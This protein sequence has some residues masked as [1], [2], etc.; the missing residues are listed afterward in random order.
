TS[1]LSGLFFG[2]WPIL[3]R[4]RRTN[5]SLREGGRHAWTRERRR[6][7]AGIVIGEVALS[8][9]LLTG[10]GLLL[11]SFVRLSGVNPGFDGKNVMTMFSLIPPARYPTPQSWATYERNAIARLQR[12]PGVTQVGAINTLPLSNIGDNTSIDV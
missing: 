11:R 10:A 6:L 1:L 5:E 3:R 12:L 7:R 9:V 2:L 4:D 8:I